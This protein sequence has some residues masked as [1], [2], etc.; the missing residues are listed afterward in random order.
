V[1]PTIA[2]Y[3]K[4]QKYK[5]KIIGKTGYINGVRS[6]SGLC[7]TEQ[8]DYIFSILTNNTNGQTRTVINNIAKAI[9]D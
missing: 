9:F 4:E 7:V 8:G 1:K 3:F 5:G 2:R 6:F